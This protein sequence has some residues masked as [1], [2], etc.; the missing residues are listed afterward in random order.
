MM[1]EIIAGLFAAAALALGS[2]RA[3]TPADLV[4]AYPAAFSG[5]EGNVLVWRDGTRMPISTQPAGR[6]FD[7]ILE[8]PDIAEMFS[9]PY[10]A[11]PPAAPPGLND[12][13]GRIIYAPLFRKMYGDCSKGQ[14]T[15]HMRPVAW[16][17][18][19]GGGSVM[20]STVNGA[21]KALEAVVRDLEAL[22]ASMTRYLVPTGGTYNCRVVAGTDRMSLHAYGVAIDIST[23]F[24]DYWLWTDPKGVDPI[25]YRNQVPFAIAQIFERH[26][27]IWGGKWYHYDTMH[28]EYRP[29]LLP[30]E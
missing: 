17:P 25:P 30:A 5:I 12:D 4:R 22:P 1:R 24:T 8:S 6:T 18:S 26:G 3:A 29:E 9:I 7:Q 27:F 19:R 16:M 15:P 21:D 11:G 13:P 2:A 28:F 20:F 14:V 23:K 10:V